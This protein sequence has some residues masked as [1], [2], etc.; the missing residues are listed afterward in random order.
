M[1]GNHSLKINMRFCFVNFFFIIIVFINKK[2]CFFYNFILLNFD[3]F[4][5]KILEK[6]E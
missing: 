6:K 1:H 4:S 5:C 3:L 2:I